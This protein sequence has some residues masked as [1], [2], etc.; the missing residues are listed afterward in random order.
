MKIDLEEKFLDDLNANIGI[1]HR[2]CNI[3]FTDRQERQDGFQ[4]I[5]Y[6][7]WKSYP[8][9]KGQSKF[10]T[11][12]YRVALNTAISGLRKKTKAL[13]NEPLSDKFFE[14]AASSEQALVDEQMA[15]LYAAINDLSPL[16]KAI[17]LLYLEDT[18]YDQISTIVG[19]SKNHV[20]VKLVRIK[21]KLEEKLRNT[22][23]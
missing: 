13:K 16:D 20:S 6:Q 3:Y 12:M 23:N 11:W 21:K 19:I 1:V 4:E 17:V 5:L 7:L 14:I 15:L 10:S 2:I 22:I 8:N 18:S 9:F